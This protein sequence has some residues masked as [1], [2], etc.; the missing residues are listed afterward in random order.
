MT[1]E[2]AKVLAHN[3]TTLHNLEGVACISLEDGQPLDVDQIVGEPLFTKEGKH[4]TPKDVK[5]MLWEH[6]SDP[7]LTNLEGVLL[8]SVHDGTRNLSGVGLCLSSA[9]GSN[10]PA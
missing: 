3:L 5:R 2:L 1:G 4:L 7:L 10:Q 8:W 9:V 6:R